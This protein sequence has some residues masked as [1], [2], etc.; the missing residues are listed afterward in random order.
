MQKPLF[1]KDIAH[2]IHRVQSHDQHALEQLMC[3]LMPIIKQRIAHPSIASHDCDDLL[4]EI[5]IRINRN[6]THLQINENVPI[7]HYFNRLIKT[8]KYDYYRK[9]NR[10]HH[11]YEQL[12]A[13][14]NVNYVGHT[15]ISVEAQLIL[16]E[17]VQLLLMCCKK[18]S[19]LEQEVVQY[20]LDDYSPNEI[21]EAMGVSVKAVY[22]ALHRCKKKLRVMMNHLQ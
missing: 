17:Q 18:L 8:S 15:C 10:L 11:Q 16:K 20:I 19:K 9:Q 6:L 14:A 13:E 7:E 21:A 3:I 1:P 2:L 22:N 5:F 12:I 4:Q